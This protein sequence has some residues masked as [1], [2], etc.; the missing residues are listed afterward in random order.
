MGARGSYLYLHG[1]PMQVVV[2]VPCCSTNR[3]PNRLESTRKYL[4]YLH[5]RVTFG[6][7][8]HDMRGRGSN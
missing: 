3:P 5:Y 2:V 8:R 4:I 7:A 1:E 6:G